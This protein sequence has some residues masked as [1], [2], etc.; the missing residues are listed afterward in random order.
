[1]SGP[2]LTQNYK[3]F[4][5]LSPGNPVSVDAIKDDLGINYYSVAVYIHELKRLF[6]AEIDSVRD[7]RKVV[8]YKLNNADKI[9]KK[10]KPY[11]SNNAQYVKPTKKAA[12]VSDGAI[13]TLDPETDKL[14]T[15]SDNEMADIKESLGLSD[16]GGGDFS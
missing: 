7:G 6:H 12:P 9:A 10:I 5:L 8:A 15:V 4:A 14:T 11:R 16:F 1:M 13:P 2:K 3:L